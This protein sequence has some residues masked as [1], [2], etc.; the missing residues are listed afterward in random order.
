[1]SDEY[2]DRFIELLSNPAFGAL[3][4]MTQGFASAAMPTRMP[5]PF[6]AVLGMGAGG[7]L[8][9]AQGAQRLG[10]GTQQAEKARIE[11][12]RAKMLLDW[13]NQ[14]YGGNGA[15]MGAPM[16]SGGGGGAAGGGGPDYLVS[17]AKYAGLGDLA[18]ATGSDRAAA[19]LY[20]LPNTM[21]GGAG[22]AMGRDGTGFFVPGGAADPRTVQNKSFAEAQG[23]VGPAISQAAGIQAVEAPYKPPVTVDVPQYDANGVQTGTVQ[24][25]IPVAEWA[26]RN[27]RG[28]GSSGAASGTVMPGS[29]YS[30]RIAMAENGGGAPDA[31]NPRSSATGNGQ[32]IDSTWLGQFKQTFPDQAKGMSDDQ[33]L[34]LRSN[35]QVS[36][37]MIQAHGQTNA[38]LLAKA[39]IP[40]NATTLALAHRLGPAGAITVLQ[41]PPNATLDK[42]LPAN[43]IEKNPE[44][45][46]MP[47]G[48]LVGNTT[49]RFGMAP[50]QFGPAGYGGK[51]ELTPQAKADLDVQ[52]KW[53]EPQILRP[54]GMLVDPANRTEIKNP[55]LVQTQDPVT[56][57]T[58]PVHVH[59][60]SPYAPH[61]TP[62]EATPIVQGGGQ[63]II[64]KVPEQQQKAR[65]EATKQ[66]LGK[67]TDAYIAA[68][69]THGWLQQIDNAAD[70]MNKAGPLYMTGPYAA[71][72]YKLMSQA[73][74]MARTLGFK[75]A[76][77]DQ[78]A[79]A[80]WEE[81]RKATT[82]AGF[83]LSSHYEGHARQAASTI[84]NATSAVPG[85]KN[86]PEGVKLVSAGIREGAQ[87]AIDVHEYK[88]GIYDK[89]K[90]AG[91]E[92]AETDFYKANT[93]DMYAKRAISSVHPIDVRAET[94]AAAQR[95]FANYLPGTVVNLNGRMKIVPEREG[96][97]PIPA[98]IKQKFMGAGGG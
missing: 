16:A 11:N 41:S 96:A 9:G 47:V 22:Y 36:D 59:P 23:K 46:G 21:A 43:V 38:P 1:M 39:G 77:F 73:N 3:S 19:T 52:T 8:Q 83:E 10:L 5:T 14:N 44:F 20:A 91:L 17:P 2:S 81:L 57:A 85:D 7:M 50:V 65:D 76:P 72:R 18:M 92:T 49:M 63:P 88:Q 78:S 42:V 15:P 40:A 24:Q 95:A 13:Y 28:G 75:N 67:D 37:A 25:Q 29:V 30:Q 66:F 54:G 56:G 53:R 69:N 90:G 82:T 4:G 55:E 61:G 58:V 80:S 98:Y 31:R 94:P 68:K 60:A 62:G 86:S 6:G 87:S 97:P 35:P 70:T 27:R 93:P 74:D 45:R 12:Q 48:A 51:V 32:F 89:T 84:E 26:A 64:S 71:E 33:I 79:I 34:G